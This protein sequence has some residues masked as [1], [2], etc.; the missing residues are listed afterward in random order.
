MREFIWC[1]GKH[2]EQRKEAEVEMV[3]T[4][5]SSPSGRPFPKLCS[6]LQAVDKFPH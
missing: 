2:Q 4:V 1:E 6:F 5:V 3:D